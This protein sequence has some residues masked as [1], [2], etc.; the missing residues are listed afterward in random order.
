MLNIDGASDLTP[1][2]KRHFGRMTRGFERLHTEIVSILQERVIQR[3]LLKACE[4]QEREAGYVTEQIC[5]FD[6]RGVF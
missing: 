5:S 2:T 3:Q 4:K 6:V 1:R